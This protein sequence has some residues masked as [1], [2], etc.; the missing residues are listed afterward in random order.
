MATFK[1]TNVDEPAIPATVTLRFISK[2]RNSDG[3][4]NHDGWEYDSP[5]GRF[6][7]NAR[8]SRRTELDDTEPRGQ[9]LPADDVSYEN[10]CLFLKTFCIRFRDDI[11]ATFLEQNGSKSAHGIPVQGTSTPSPGPSSPDPNI[12]TSKSS[13]IASGVQPSSGNSYHLA[14]S[15]SI[16]V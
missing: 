6:V 10:Q 3:Q 15:V 13:F 1:R 12:A 5:G 8:V 9:S 2:L 14:H 11:W 7:I 4:R 16:T